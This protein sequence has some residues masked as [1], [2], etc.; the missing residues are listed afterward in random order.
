MRWPRHVIFVF[1]SCVWPIVTLANQSPTAQSDVVNALAITQLWISLLHDVIKI[2]IDLLLLH[3]IERSANSV[4]A[5]FERTI[6]DDIA[7]ER[8]EASPGLDR[9]L[10][11]AVI[12]FSLRVSAV[13]TVIAVHVYLFR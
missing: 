5:F 2:V 9:V 7:S 1:I 10:L 6:L 3:F 4:A 13:L 12:V 11:A 8:L